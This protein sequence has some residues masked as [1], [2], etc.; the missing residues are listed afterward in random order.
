MPCFVLSLSSEYFQRGIFLV[1]AKFFTFFNTFIKLMWFF[2]VV[3]PLIVTLL[4]SHSW[5]TLNNRYC[6]TLTTLYVTYWALLCFVILSEFAFQSSQSVA[7]RWY[8]Y[9]YHGKNRF[10]WY[11]FVCILFN[12]SFQVFQCMSKVC[13]RFKLRMWNSWF[14]KLEIEIYVVLLRYF[15]G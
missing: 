12:F 8:V 14:I 1:F 9:F 3:M 7:R 10:S 6:S 2:R 11:T 4:Q 13:W 5:S 15:H